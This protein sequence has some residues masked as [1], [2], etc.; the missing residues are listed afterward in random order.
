MIQSLRRGLEI[1]DTLAE[2]GGPMRCKALAG[3]LGVDTSTA[4]RMLETLARRGYVRKDPQSKMYT[5]GVRP[6]ALARV[7][8]GRLNVRAIA[9]ETLELL[10]GQTGECLHLAIAQEGQAVF[11]DSISGSHILTA[12]TEVGQTEP[13]YCTAVG[14]ALLSTLDEK[15]VRGRLPKERRTFTSNT[16][17]TVRGVLEDLVECRRR[18]W[19]EDDEEYQEGIRCVAS[20]IVDFEG[21]VVASIGLSAPKARMPKGRV[22]ELGR[23]LKAAAA[24]ISAR[25][26]APAKDADRPTG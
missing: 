23:M 18:G 5:L 22:T 24:D 11:V 20:W 21:N 4:H 8:L 2:A 16:H 1:L 25:L 6:V 9:R 7:F 3:R 15:D 14:K 12:N 26:G 10:A 17:A 13:L 19:S